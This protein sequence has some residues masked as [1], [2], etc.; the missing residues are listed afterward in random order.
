MPEVF[1][2]TVKD[3]IIPVGAT[4]LEH[5]GIIPGS[6]VITGPDKKSVVLQGFDYND[7]SFG[8]RMP[9]LCTAN[10]QYTLTI[11]KQQSNKLDQTWVFTNQALN[12][13]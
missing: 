3:E 12:I 13:Y 5:V 10:Y 4:R 9:F 8:T 11:V 7:G 2:A 1:L 6:L